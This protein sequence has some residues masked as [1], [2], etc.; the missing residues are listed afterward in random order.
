MILEQFTGD[1]ADHLVVSGVK[2]VEQYAAAAGV[3]SS[4]IMQAAAAN[5][6]YS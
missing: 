2:R 4:E 6:V 1:P 5:S 3:T